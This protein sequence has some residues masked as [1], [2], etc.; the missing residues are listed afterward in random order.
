[1]GCV[2]SDGIVC[3]FMYGSFIYVVILLRFFFYGYYGLVD[4]SVGVIIVVGNC[5]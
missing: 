4:V 3:V 1:M 5:M 2:C